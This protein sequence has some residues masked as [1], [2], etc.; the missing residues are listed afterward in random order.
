MNRTYVVARTLTLALG[1]IAVSNAQDPT[2]Q[3]AGSQSFM[4]SSQVV[5]LELRN[6]QNESI[7]KI[8]DVIFDNNGQ[9]AYVIVGADAEGKLGAVPWNAVKPAGDG[10][11]LTVNL[12]KEKIAAAPMFERNTW[13]DFADA[14]WT[15][16]VRSFY[17]VTD[18]PNRMRSVDPMARDRASEAE[19]R[20]ATRQPNMG[21]P[22]DK[23]TWEKHNKGSVAS[24]TGTVKSVELGDETAVW[25]TT[26]QGDIH[27]MVAPNAFLERERVTFQVGSPVTFKG[28]ESVKDGTRHL[29]VSEYVM[30]DGRSIRFRRD[31]Q[32]PV[33]TEERVGTLRDNQSPAAGAPNIRDLSGTVSYVEAG[34]CESAQGR[35]AYIRTND[36]ERVV[37]LGPGTYLDQQRWSLRPND[38][39]SV[40]GYDH[41]RDGRRYFL[42]TEVR[43]GNDTWTLR[44]NDGT[45]A[46]R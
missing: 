38:Q 2:R 21:D 35:L 14:Q 28:Y 10:R 9:V 37:A 32:S 43:R 4:R 3:P 25:V 29:T 36:G 33:W 34:A 1:L 24:V 22:S 7:G 26:P 40:R 15:T 20:D 30:N 13:P 17:G 41:E 16:Q 39:I 6:H 27:A 45:P 18:S 23:K 12:T 8:E 11:A 5:G 44:N 31:D 42:A 19:R 46:W